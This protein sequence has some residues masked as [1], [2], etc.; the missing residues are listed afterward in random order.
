[1]TQIKV[2]PFL[3]WHT[4]KDLVAM[5]QELTSKCGHK[6]KLKDLKRAYHK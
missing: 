3:R 5:A 2:T 1:M 4:W 6:G